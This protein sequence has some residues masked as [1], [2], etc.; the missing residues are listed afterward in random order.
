M[1][2]SRGDELSFNV[3]P[4]SIVLFDRKSNV[5]LIRQFLFYILFY[6]IICVIALTSVYQG[7]INS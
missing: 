5:N 2:L 4:E 7:K 1:G 3:S 6:I